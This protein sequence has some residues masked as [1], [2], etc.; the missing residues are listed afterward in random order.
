[1]SDMVQK[2][3]TI[4]ILLEEIVDELIMRNFLDGYIV[5]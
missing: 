5:I 2:E 1:M 4:R 3:N